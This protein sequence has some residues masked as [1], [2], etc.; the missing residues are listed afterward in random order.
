MRIILFT[1]LFLLSACG[2]QGPGGG[3]PKGIR[4]SEAD[5]AYARSAQPE[6]EALAS[7]YNRSCRNCHAVAGVNAPLTGHLAAW[8]PRLAER[9]RDGLLQSTRSGYRAM[10]AQGLCRQCSDEDFL[11][12]IDFM[13]TPPD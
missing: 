10:P 6:D 1:L 7:I 8:E 9:S 2:E 4:P 13:L 11:A 12:L 3:E 5:I